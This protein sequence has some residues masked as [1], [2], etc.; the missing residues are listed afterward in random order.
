MM[1][2]KKKKSAFTEYKISGVGSDIFPLPDH[3]DAIQVHKKH[4]GAGCSPSKAPAELLPPL[5]AAAD[6]PGLRLVHL[7]PPV[8]VI[9]DFWS[10]E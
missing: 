7:Y 4:K 2:S 9:D 8:C 5:L 10:A 1:G 3:R 6:Y